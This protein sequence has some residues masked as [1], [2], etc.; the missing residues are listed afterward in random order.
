MLKIFPDEKCGIKHFFSQIKN[1]II[2]LS[3]ICF[4][5][6]NNIKDKLLWD[7]QKIIT[8]G[9]NNRKSQPYYE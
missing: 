3:F 7:T 4:Q 5:V 8:F 2:F 6:D 1:G 9:L